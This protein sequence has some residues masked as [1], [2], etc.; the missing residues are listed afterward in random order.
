[1]IKT[2]DRQAINATP[3][4]MHTILTLHLFDVT[5][6]DTL[7]P[8]RLLQGRIRGTLQAMTKSFHEEDAWT[9]C[10][11]ATRTLIKP[12]G[13]SSKLAVYRNIEVEGIR[14]YSCLIGF[15]IA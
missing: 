5:N 9:A 10:H 8:R 1:M 2:L 6:V 4:R 14:Y 3:D 15:L 7:N 13:D 11:L 12:S